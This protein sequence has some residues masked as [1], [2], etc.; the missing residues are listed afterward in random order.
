MRGV[1]VSCDVCQKGLH[2]CLWRPQLAGRGEACLIGHIAGQIMAPCVNIRFQLNPV[3]QR[4]DPANTPCVTS[5]GTSELGD[6]DAFKNL[7]L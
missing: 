3:L 5:A 1:R 2:V 4:L 6:Y 7:F